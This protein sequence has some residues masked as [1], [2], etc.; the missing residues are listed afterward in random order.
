MAPESRL[1]VPFSPRVYKTHG[2]S[3]QLATIVLFYL[4]IIIIPLLEVL[5]SSSNI[6][7]SES[8]P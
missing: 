6:I 1:S 2:P 8:M 5:L 3:S 7:K 4:G